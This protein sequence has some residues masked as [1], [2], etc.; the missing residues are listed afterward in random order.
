MSL[1]TQMF[2]FMLNPVKG[3]PHQAALDYH[4]KAASGVTIRAGM[5]CSLNAAGE[6]VPGC[7]TPFG[8][9]ELITGTT[10]RGRCDIFLSCSTP[11]GIIELIT[12]RS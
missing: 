10:R 4:A 6:L 3:W 2:E 11:F 8:I 1:F 12:K 5:A 7:S 9:T